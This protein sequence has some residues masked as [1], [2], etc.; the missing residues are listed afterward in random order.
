MSSNEK[1]SSSSS[2]GGDGDGSGT[3][4]SGNSPYFNYA[5]SD[6]PCPYRT[7]G[8]RDPEDVDSKPLHY[9]DDLPQNEA[10][11]DEALR[12]AKRRELR[13]WHP[14]NKKTGDAEKFK[15]ANEAYDKIKNAEQ[16]K[17]YRDEKSMKNYTDQDKKIKEFLINM[18][19]SVNPYHVWLCVS[20]ILFFLVSMPWVVALQIDDSLGV[21]WPVALIPFWIV[22]A[23]ILSMVMY[24]ISTIHIRKAGSGAIA[25]T[26]VTCAATCA[27]L[28]ISIVV[29][30]VF[31]VL[32]NDDA[33]F[34]D[35]NTI[36]I[37]PLIIALC[38]CCVLCTLATATHL[39]KS[40][41]LSSFGHSTPAFW[42]RCTIFSQCGIAQAIM[43]A[44]KLNESFEK[45]WTHT[46]IPSIVFLSSFG[47][48]HL[49]SCVVTYVECGHCFRLG[50]KRQKSATDPESQAFIPSVAE[51]LKIKH[52]E[53][54]FLALQYFF[55]GLVEFLC[56]LA[57]VGSFVLLVM[58]LSDEEDSGED[59]LS[60]ILVMA[61]VNI[62]LAVVV[63]TFVV[64]FYCNASAL[65]N[66]KTHL[67][68]A[69]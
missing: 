3:S 43:V 53:S 8:F 12:L 19:N 34:L 30:E 17:I 59:A 22:D 64:I 65:K 18:N 63:V 2:S 49:F 9:L 5:L 26:N 48:L 24:T 52:Q 16:R 38:S 31:V 14:D 37:V 47:A 51:E 23:C 54:F 67:R 55:V 50:R 20:L 6:E 42:L 61:P 56:L 44:M 62:F 21:S 45:S 68:K 60:A 35:D 57:S 29:F 13:Y 7:L 15:I 4:S 40:I 66:A 41:T 36:L 33:A 32:S 69:G 10:D 28:M 25:A 58:K 1:R 46:L 27:V 39:P 11:R